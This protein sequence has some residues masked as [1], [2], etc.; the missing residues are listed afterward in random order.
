MGE[1]TRLGPG[2]FWNLY[3][4]LT[5]S[6]NLKLLE[7]ESIN[8]KKTNIHGKASLQFSHFSLQGVCVCLCVLC[9]YVCVCMCHAHTHDVHTASA[10][11]SLLF[12]SSFT[13]LL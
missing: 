7:K 10:I 1:S 8:F 5:F 2:L 11:P 4:P 6:V 3:S 9:V 12:L 13:Y